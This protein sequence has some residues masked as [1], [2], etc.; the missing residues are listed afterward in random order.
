[1]PEF[2]RDD[3]RTRPTPIYK[4]P[5]GPRRN[6]ALLAMGKKVKIVGVAIK[7][8]VYGGVHYV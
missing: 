6:P 7:K 4:A 8:G 2:P 5:E 1:M 3:G